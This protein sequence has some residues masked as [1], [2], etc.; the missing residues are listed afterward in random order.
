MSQPPPGGKPNGTGQLLT[1]LAQSGDKWIQ[2]AVLVLVGITGLGNWL[3]TQ[4]TS[5]QQLQGQQR[6]RDEVIQQVGQSYRWTKDLHDQIDDF[7]KRQK[8]IM[9][10]QSQIIRRLDELKQ[11]G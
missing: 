1:V 3:A 8:Q 11:H 5:Q 6:I 4:N 9:D 10:N 7:E 2:F